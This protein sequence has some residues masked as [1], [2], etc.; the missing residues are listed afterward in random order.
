MIQGFN[1]TLLTIQKDIPNTTSLLNDAIKNQRV[2]QAQ[3]N[4]IIAQNTSLTNNM[5]GI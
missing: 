1:V 3:L 4:S 5:S 2:A